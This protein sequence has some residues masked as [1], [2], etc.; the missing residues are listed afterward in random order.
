M[1]TSAEENMVYMFNPESKDDMRVFLHTDK[2]YAIDA[3]DEKLITGD[4]AGMV[5]VWDVKSGNKLQTLRG[6]SL[7][8]YRVSILSHVIVSVALDK[9]LIVWDSNT[10]ESLRVLDITFR[11]MDSVHV[12]QNYIL[13]CTIRKFRAWDLRTGK[14]VSMDITKFP[15]YGYQ[16]YML[17]DGKHFVHRSSVIEYWPIED[18]IRAFL[19]EGSYWC[20]QF[21]P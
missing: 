8:V 10:G 13:L 11:F 5:I 15:E 16:E 3:T 20:S 4:A 21:T 7:G 17:K 18:T 12:L 19:G 2:I 6:H 14:L 1:C 9:R